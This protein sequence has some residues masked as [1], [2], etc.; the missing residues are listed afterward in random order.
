[1]Q[2]TIF[3]SDHEAFR[4]GVVR[5]L[6][7]EVA[8]HVDRFREQGCVDREVWLKAG[9]QSLLCP[10]VSEAYG[11]PGITDFR[12]DMIISEEIV[13]H[14]DPALYIPLHSRIV[15]PYIQHFGSESQ[16]R[17]WL[18]GAVS[19][20]TILAVAMTEPG[21]GSDLAG[22]RTHAEQHGDHWVLNGSKTYISNGILADL[23]VVAART[24][25]AS[26]HGLTLFLVERGME[27]FERGR[28]LKKMGLDAQDTAELFFNNVKVPASHVLGQPGKGFVYL[29]SN[30]AE[31]RLMCA[32]GS[33]AH[34]NT[35]FDLTLQYVKERRAFGRAI[36]TFQN[37]R[38]KLAELRAMLDC[39]QVFVDQL[40][41]RHI[42][43]QLDAVSASEAKL[44]ATELEGRVLDECVQ[45]HGGAGYMDEYRIS[46][47]YRDGRISRIFAG[48]NEIMRE[49]IG[50]SLGLDE[51]KQG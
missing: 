33:L 16:R 22:I 8:P 46:R 10:W 14:A 32:V 21:T 23:V 40:A 11:G 42:A 43:G 45:L 26:S 37:A 30:L 1:M 48:T 38:F 27:G 28:R 39:Q 51:R 35:A 9:A 47:M 31:E 36:G 49:I 41:L 6:Q 3:D 19:G 25:P 12:Y 44:L 7:K 50:R 29:A 15:A 17:R 4:D 24:D 5:F 18:P 2:R 13:R 20:E 34:A